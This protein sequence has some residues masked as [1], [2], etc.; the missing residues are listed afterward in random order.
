VST[1]ISFDQRLQNLTFQ[2]LSLLNLPEALGHALHLNL[3]LIECM[4]LI[5]TFDRM[6][7]D[8]VKVFDNVVRAIALNTCKISLLTLP[9]HVKNLTIQSFVLRVLRKSK[10]F[11]DIQVDI[12]VDERK[13]DIYRLTTFG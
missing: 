9:V 3:L 11:L 5:L 4:K 7:V 2:I 10:F 6:I 12:A 13:K 1:R 8:F